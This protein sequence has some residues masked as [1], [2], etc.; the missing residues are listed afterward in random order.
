MRGTL[1]TLSGCL[2]IAA[3]IGAASQVR[4]APT[5]LTSGIDVGAKVK[6]FEP[7]H[8]AGPNRGTRTCPVC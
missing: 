5:G 4:T 1:V 3:A 6:S 2:M 8:V 7:M